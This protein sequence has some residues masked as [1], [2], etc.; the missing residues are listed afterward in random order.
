MAAGCGAA[1]GGCGG[2]SGGGA[3]E[4]RGARRPASVA[5]GAAGQR[6]REVRHAVVKVDR[7][8]LCGC[9]VPR[10]SLYHTSCPGANAEPLGALPV[11]AAAAAAGGVTVA[12]P[13]GGA[14]GG[15]AAGGGAAGG[16]RRRRRR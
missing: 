5:D 16:G 7:I 15:G 12:Y 2:C 13:G 4:V 11:A 10:L 8:D 6:H 1:A 14:A 9:C 3:A